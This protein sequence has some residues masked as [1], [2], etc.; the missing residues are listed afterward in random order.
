M[1]FDYSLEAS[2]VSARKK[3]DATQSLASTEK[4]V[5]Y[6]KLDLNDITR[7]YERYK[8]KL[9]DERLMDLREMLQL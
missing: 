3:S 2:F 5:E 7:E 4:K 8:R 6:P 1:N 9:S